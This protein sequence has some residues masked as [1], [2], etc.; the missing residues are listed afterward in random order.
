MKTTL[1]DFDAIVDTVV[2]QP[3]T[4][5]F[6]N[7][8]AP[9]TDSNIYGFQYA[10]MFVTGTSSS[11]VSF[12]IVSYT[13]FPY[14]TSPASG[15]PSLGTTV[16][17]TGTATPYC[18]QPTPACARDISL[19]R[20]ATVGN[21][22]LAAGIFCMRVGTV[23]CQSP[24]PALPMNQL[25]FSFIPGAAPASQVSNFLSLGG[26]GYPFTATTSVPWASVSPAS[27][28]AP[29]ALTVT[30][31]PTSLKPGTYTGTLSITAE[32][33][34]EI[35]NLNVVV[36]GLP[37]IS[38]VQDSGAWSTT[39]TPGGFATI[40]GSGFTQSPVSWSP[41]SNLPTNLGGVQVQID[42]KSAFI[43]YASFGQ[44]NV[45][46]PPDSNSG[47]VTATLTTTAGSSTVS[48]NLAPMKPGWFTYTAGAATWIAAQIANTTTLVAPAGYFGS[49]ATSRPAKAGDFI[50]LY[51][52]GLGATNPAA[53]V[54]TVF[55][56]AYPLANPAQ[57]SLTISGEPVPVQFAG[58]RVHTGF[59]R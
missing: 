19:F 24:M 26:S 45:L 35:V 32:Q 9:V 6:P 17:F 2:F 11:P 10:P 16:T 47:M 46:V 33:V 36:A 13:Q 23:F 14:Q 53:P 27:G 42:G 59:M 48:V 25:N 28:A 37:V 1:N 4:L 22:S 21:T 40:F 38:S 39:I 31:D 43:S 56:G 15:L 3:Q 55:S 51:A 57:V 30:V 58:L 29:Q 50:T 8:Q 41:T 49:G 18:F 7:V 12:E 34:T 5:Q 52:N 54:G 44:V 20:H